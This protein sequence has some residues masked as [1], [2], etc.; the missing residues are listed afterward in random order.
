MVTVL[1][2][3]HNH[4]TTLLPG[5]RKPCCSCLT[6]VAVL[7][8]FF[9]LQQQPQGLPTAVNDNDGEDCPPA[10]RPAGGG[11]N[12]R[13]AAR[14]ARPRLCA[15]RRAGNSDACAAQPA[16]CV[17]SCC[18][19]YAALVTGESCRVVTRSMGATTAFRSTASLHVTGHVRKCLQHTAYL[20]SKTHAS[21]PLL[22]P[23]LPRHRPDR[24]PSPAKRARRWH[25][26]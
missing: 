10:R 16:G 21:V 7:A 13:P 4:Q 22:Q 19:L 12:Q 23:V 2:C 24:A 15:C 20:P 26:A 1:H 14:A 25:P 5:L 18:A 3:Q 6:L 11:S 8:P 9:L 17:F